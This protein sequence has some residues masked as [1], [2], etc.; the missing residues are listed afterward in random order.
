MERGPRRKFVFTINY[1]KDNGK[2][3]SS[4]LY[5]Y[6]CAVIDSGNRDQ[7]YINDVIAHIRGL[8]DS[9]G[10]GAMPGLHHQSEGWD[11]F[12]MVQHGDSFPTLILPRGK[13]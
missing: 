4:Y 1:F 2:W 10:Q 12:I 8:R 11:G 13:T 9:G 3:Y 7:P 6:E 5:E